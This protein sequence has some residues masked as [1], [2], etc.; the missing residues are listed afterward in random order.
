MKDFSEIK[1]A[2]EDLQR[3]APEVKAIK[4]DKGD[5]GEP[6]RG[7][8]WR[9]KAHKGMGFSTNDVVHYDGSAWICTMPTTDLPPSDSWSLMA[10]AVNGVNGLDGRVGPQGPPG[11]RGAEGL[12]GEPGAA[13]LVW[14]GAY[15]TGQQYEIGDVVS[16][17][18]GSYVCVAQTT[19]PPVT[20]NGW[21][22]LA[23]RGKVGMQGPRGIVEDSSITPEKLSTGGPSWTVGGR[24]TVSGNAMILEGTQTPA[25][26]DG[27]KPGEIA[28]GLD[29]G[30][31]YL[32]YCI[33]S[34]NWARVQLTQVY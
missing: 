15:R 33:A 27:G 2:I 32:Y 12:K 34:G 25:S 10:K 9:G 26:N 24:M 4:G 19:Q 22:V 21:Q 16:Y 1:K 18:G 13:G 29:G 5:R 23:D 31:A 6:G 3:P 11:P 7:F 28:F 20:G 30:S 8:R 17:D 14:Q